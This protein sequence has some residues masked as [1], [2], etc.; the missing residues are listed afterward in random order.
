MSRATDV[1]IIGVSGLLP[2]AESFAALHDALLH[3]RSGVAVPSADRLRFSGAALDAAYPKLGYLD[4]IDLFD[5]EFFGLTLGEAVLMDPQQRLALQLVHT[6]VENAGYAVQD[7]RGSQTSV[8]LS[9]S[10]TGYETLVEDDPQLL[11]G[12]SRAAVAARVSYLLDLRGPSIVVDT[13]CSSAL[14]AVVTAVEH[15]RRGEATLA[16]AGGVNVNAVLMTRENMPPP[17]EIISPDETCRPFDA[18][19]NGSVAGEGGGFVVLKPLADAITDGDNVHAVIKGVAVNHNGFRATGMSAPSPVGQAEVIADAWRDAGTDGRNVTYVE[20]H[21]SGTRLG[22]VI[23]VDGLNRAFVAAGAGPGHCAIGSVK[24]NVGHLDH[25]A[26]IAGLLKVLSALRSGVRYPAPNYT[27]PNP[28]T[29]VTG[30]VYVGAQADD[31]PRTDGRPRQAGV[32]S[33]GLTG[34]NVHVVLQ[35]APEAARTAETGTAELVTLSARTPAALARYCESVAEFAAGTEHTLASVAHVLNRGR[36]DFPYRVSSTV[37]SLGRLTESLKTVEP[38]TLPVG[39]APQVVL[40]VPGDGNLDEWSSL[41]NAFPSLRDQQVPGPAGRLHALCLLAGE[42]GLTEAKLAGSGLGN[43]A[44]DL[45]RGR[46]TTEQAAELALGTDNTAEPNGEGLSR[47]VRGW[48]AED[49]VL[50]ELCPGGTLSA[51]IAELAPSLR[52]ESLTAAPTRDGVLAV[53]GRL[54]EQGVEI[55]WHRHYER[56]HIPRIE[57]PTYPFDP[58]RCW[59]GDRRHEQDFSWATPTQ[60]RIAEIWLD[61]LKVAGLGPDSD[62]FELGGTSIAGMTVL[63]RINSEC[64]A[65]VRF[66]D[67]YEFRTIRALA[68][69]VDRT[70]GAPGGPSMRITPVPR[71]G[72]LPLSLGQRQLWLMQQLYPATPLYNIPIDLRFHGP[73][74]IPALEDALR[75]LIDR[76]EVL[77]TGLLDDDGEPRG[78]LVEKNFALPV[79]DLSGLPDD[80]R[81][82]QV[83]RRIAAS[84]TA[85]VDLEHGPLGAASILKLADD[86][87]VFAITLHHIAYD[88]G[89]SLIFFRELAELYEARLRDR[90]HTLPPLLVQYADYAAW[91]R[92]WLN[93]ESVSKSRAFW[94]EQLAGIVPADLP[95]DHARPAER[96]YAGDFVEFT[97]PQEI[98]DR[99]REYSRRHH[100]TTFATMLAVVNAFLHRWAGFTDVVVGSPT[101]GR[102]NPDT[103][104]LIGYFNNVLPMRVAV[105]GELSFDELVRRCATA[106]AT[107]LDHEAVPI[108]VIVSDVRP[109]REPGRNPLFDV[110]YVHQN[111]PSAPCELTGT[112]TSRYVPSDVYGVAPGTSKFDL[113]M[114][115][116]EDGT[117]PLLGYFEYSADLFER[118]TVER[119]V[120][121]FQALLVAAIAQP[122]AALASL[123]FGSDAP[124]SDDARTVVDLFEEHVAQ[125]PDHPALVTDE[126]TLSYR[127]LD[128]K[129]NSLAWRLLDAGVRA[130]ETVAVIAGRGAGLVISWLAVAKAGG[131]YATIDSGLPASRVHDLLAGLD[132]RIVVAES[133]DAATINSVPHGATVLLAEDAGAN[134]SGENDRAPARSITGQSLVYVNYTS[135]STGRPNGCEIEHGN[136]MAFMRWYLRDTGLSPADR[137]THCAGPG[138][139]ASNLEVWGSL[140]AGASLHVSSTIRQDPAVLLGWLAQHGVTVAFLP[141]PVAELVLAEDQPPGLAL[142]VLVTGGDRLRVRPT[143]RAG[144]R[145]VN[146]YGPTETTIVTTAGPVAAGSDESWPGIGRPIDGVAL[147]VLD[148]RGNQVTPGTVGEL[149]VAGTGVGRGYHGMPALTAQRFV[150]DPFGEPGSRMYRTG[151]MVRLAGDGELEFHGRRDGQVKIR[152][153]RVEL[154]EIEHMLLTHPAVR[155]AAAVAVRGPGGSA[156]IV[157]FAEGDEQAELL[158]D[159]LRRRLPG[160]MTPARLQMLPVLPLTPHGKIDRAA[161]KEIAMPAAQHS[162][163]VASS[164]FSPTERILAD[165]WCDTLE[166]DRVRAHDDFFDLGG[167]SFLAIRVVARAARAGIRLRPQDLVRHQTLEQLAAFVELSGEGTA[168]PTVTATT[169]PTPLTPIQRLFMTQMS[170]K[171]RWGP[172]I[173]LE[174]PVGATPDIIRRIVRHIMDRH[175]VLRARFR[176]N[177][178]DWQMEYLDTEPHEIVHSKPMPA[179][180]GKQF[181]YDTMNQMVPRL[182]LVDGPLVQATFLDRGAGTAGLLLLVINH[183]V[184]DN[185]SFAGLLDDLDTAWE[186]IAADVPLPPRPQTSAWRTWVHDLHKQSTSDTLAAE[187][188]YWTQVLRT[189]ADL[190]DLDGTTGSADDTKLAVR[191]IDTSQVPAALLGH[192]DVSGRDVALSAVAVAVSR[193]NGRGGAYIMLEGDGHTNAFTDV[194]RSLAVGWFTT[195]YPI[196]LEA[197]AEASVE[198]N[199]PRLLDQ[200]RSRPNN[201]VG[202]GMLRHLAPQAPGVA[203]LRSL[204]EPR[205][206]LNHLA[207]DTASLRV[208]TKHFRPRSDI[209]MEPEPIT[210][211]FPL[212]LTITADNGALRVAAIHAGHYPDDS[213][214]SLL[215]HLVRAITELP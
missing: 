2:N 128:R 197:D 117:C 183:F 47:A 151:D 120:E 74:D 122:R 196:A 12:V 191:T 52:I 143:P 27:A 68:D 28:M 112:T 34:T 76:H 6:A 115:V 184:S 137:C 21:G 88:G 99:V 194:D 94:R 175:E 182:H 205:I 104:N 200:I 106:A 186:A 84:A 53:L 193:W 70:A 185:M 40:L 42:L 89:A 96:T 18:D 82:Q 156:R 97:V 33:F 65:Q 161:L 136:L 39:P 147:R 98:T 46:I 48:I 134:D 13:A 1:A 149:Y 45:V 210:E 50:V 71:T 213:M 179:D 19:A 57:V 199:L 202:Y 181:I 95:T 214:E 114:G 118:T 131:A 215:D 85:P 171:D 148:P 41:A 78:V 163:S 169:G 35:E 20:C 188:P 206:L 17:N 44:I 116:A 162:P 77:R 198:E 93:D 80:E 174:T 126:R 123:P 204:P 129:A 73:L 167:D 72:S 154:A 36:D 86:D 135:G 22:D 172:C 189:G 195:M 142:R 9:A 91:Q 141:T 108:D 203:E 90:P 201:G 75:D 26:G 87:H 67:L 63:R 10:D 130:G 49:T 31:W 59:P 51:R 121:Q 187:L 5:H 24:G 58:V 64:G 212:T 140:C 16:V 4:R 30:P 144:F 100:V 38:P 150:A 176:H 152:G 103:Q 8:V 180:A 56:R 164:R 60:R 69:H 113:T 83:R 132:P 105:D 209:L 125:R 192:G 207:A 211:C 190:D 178:L 3:G 159:W 155:S 157:S 102:F 158:L 79:A 133:P 101:S 25:A 119:L 32:S 145:L 37:D 160:Y 124:V 92:D 208:G 111:S 23:E 54:Y 29:D 15:L 107:T 127:E 66:V 14:A 11:L 110:C 173:A 43:V 170:T 177:G 139:D 168:A 61:V 166:I 62:Y 109:R 165:I 81:D 7:L 146:V 138:F 55:D 153:N